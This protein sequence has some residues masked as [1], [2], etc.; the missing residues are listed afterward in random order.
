MKI[1]VAGGETEFDQAAASRILAQMLR[2][3]D[4]VIGLSTGRTTVGMYF[5][6]VKVF[7]ACPFE[8]SGLTLF[9]VD[10]LTD[11]PRS[12]EGSCYAIIKS[13]LIDPLHVSEENFV[14]PPTVS[15]DFRAEC[16]RF[17]QELEKR[18][19]VDL[20]IL[21]IGENGHIGINQPGT[22][23]E[24]ET[25]VSPMDPVFEAKVRRETGVPPEQRLGGLT[26]GIKNIMQSRRIILVAKG[27]RKA[28]IVKKALFGPVTPEVPASVL[29][30]HPNCECLLDEEAAG[31]LPGN[32]FKR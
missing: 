25:W 30:L 2:K 11:L 14:M 18:G 20:Q 21:G 4:S 29:Q 16:L 32:L 19:G 27:G 24:S 26:R 15:D 17:E 6:V 7:Q 3:P 31:E 10:E 28:R 8:V 13:Q 12:Y 9:N 5:Y 22:P 23:F 1:T